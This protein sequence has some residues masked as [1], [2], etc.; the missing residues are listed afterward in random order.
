MTAPPKPITPAEVVFAEATPRQRVLSWELNGVS[1][2]PPMSI[3]QYV[4]RETTLSETALS[5]G[6]GT[7]YCIL[8]PR[9][10]PETIVSACEVTR[11]KGLVADGEGG[12]KEV[13]GYAIASVFTNPVYRAQGMAG[14][15]LQKVQEMVDE[16]AEFGALYSDIG[17]DYYTRLGWKDF[18]SAQVLFT[19]TN[20]KG[21]ELAFPSVEGA[22]ELIGEGEAAALCEK[23][24]AALTARLGRERDGGATRIA[25]LPTPEQFRWHFARDQ[26]VCQTLVG[27]EVVRRGARTADGAAW[28]L[29]DHDLR[30]KKLKVLRVVAGEGDAE[31]KRRGD[32]RALLLAALAEA[33]DWGLHK[34]LVWAPTAEQTAVVGELWREL[35]PQVQVALEEREDGSIPSLRWRGGKALDGV[36]WEDN[37]Y[38]AWC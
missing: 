38:Y 25:F 29:W 23:D 19:T 7:R 35:G 3:A 14:Y 8:H 1:W 4:G 28:I 9:D 12:V 16:T 20:G 37:E 10:D 18:R 2:A 6:G 5:A 26:Y 15:L 11:K 31:G 27:R 34:V 36:V 21:E 32:V 22:V 17:R 13:E 33:K 30:E 24:V